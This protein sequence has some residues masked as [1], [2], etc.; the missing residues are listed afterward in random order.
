MRQQYEKKRGTE[1]RSEERKSEK[2]K[3]A[4]EV[5]GI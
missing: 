4:R 3:E 2:N 1:V 5:S